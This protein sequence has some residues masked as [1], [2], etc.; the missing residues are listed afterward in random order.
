[1]K[2]PADTSSEPVTRPRSL[3]GAMEAIVVGVVGSYAFSGVVIIAA[4]FLIP[5]FTEM[6]DSS[7]NATQFVLNMVVVAA[8]FLPVILYLLSSRFS[9][10]E[11][12]FKRWPRWKDAGLAI[13]AYVPYILVLF[14]VFE[15]LSR[16]LPEHLL[17]QEQTIG[18]TQTASTPELLLVF[19]SLVII[20]P[21]F[22]E[23]IYRGFV[24]K[25]LKRSFGFIP[26]LLLSSL[27]FALA[28]GQL[29]VAVD[30]FLLGIALGSVYHVSGQV[31]ASI[32]L[33]MLKNAIAF[34]LL[35]L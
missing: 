34:S 32:S 15:L 31:W 9:V 23:M 24:F 20:T 6:V 19:V 12:G 4:S 3:W 26:A 2:T 10:K 18:F 7:S 27:V 21:V 11:L 35:F 28:H 22:E 33:H 29:N 30:T 13:A 5:G 1:M 25:G 14:G 17:N 16:F 8:G